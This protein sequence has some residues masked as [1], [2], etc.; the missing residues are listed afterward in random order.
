M[1]REHSFFSEV[2]KAE[3]ETAKRRKELR[4]QRQKEGFC[5]ME[6]RFV[7]WIYI[8]SK[9]NANPGLPGL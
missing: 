6:I 4:I 8:I 9:R 1:R 5:S 3:W 2:E 7:W